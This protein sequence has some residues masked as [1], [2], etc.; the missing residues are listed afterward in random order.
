MTNETI[1]L[2]LQSVIFA[3]MFGVG[4]ECGARRQAFE[5]IKRLDRILD[6]IDA[7][8]IRPDKKGEYDD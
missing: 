3:I 6:M 4:Y 8:T 1:R 7:G 5:F 2:I